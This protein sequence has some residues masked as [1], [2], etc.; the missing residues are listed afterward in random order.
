[1]LTHDKREIATYT[2]PRCRRRLTVLADEYG[3]HGCSCGWEPYA[4]E[5]EEEEEE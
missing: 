1:M 4:D 3:D 5:D 2:C